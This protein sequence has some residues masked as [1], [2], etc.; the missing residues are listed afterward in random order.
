M[1]GATKGKK[2]DFFLSLKLSDCFWFLIFNLLMCSNAIEK[3][4]GF[5]YLD[6]MSTLILLAG[7]ILKCLQ[8]KERVRSEGMNYR[9]IAILSCFLLLL[10]GL[11]GNLAYG[12]QQ[13]FFPIAVD[14]FTCFKFPITLLSALY[15]FADN[16]RLSE[17]LESEAR[18]LILI[19]FMLGCINLVTDIGVGSTG[20]YGIPR[21]FELFFTHPTY[22]VFFAVG[23]SLLMLK[24]P[25]K[26]RAWIIMAA[27]VCCLSLRVKGIV[28][29]MIIILLLVSTHDVQRLSAYHVILAALTAVAVGWDSY[30]T[31]FQTNGF[32]RTE[33]VRVGIQ[34]GNSLFPLGSGFATFGSFMS[35][36][37]RYYS[38]LYYQYG[39]STIWG[40]G[41][42][43]SN[44]ASDTFW[45]TVIGQ[46]GWVGLMLYALGLIS[47]IRY[48]YTKAARYKFP[49]ICGFAYLLISSTSES[50]FFNPGSVFV[51]LC[52]AI[53]VAGGFTNESK[54]KF[55]H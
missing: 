1:N 45:P 14:A 10:V 29:A 54:T 8:T 4:N 16:E 23:L 2:R 42:H 43:D 36:T 33:L 32:A 9:S 48:A 15:L 26:N 21:A 17:L 34:L 31:Y 50:A 22:L 37:S 49:V 28:Y 44:F 46:F 18:F 53:G 27:I 20:R 3:L 30:S 41:P 51:A 40:L 19:T 52:M 13:Q 25:A 35:A 5:S 38:V 24:D 47:L 55:N 39:L 12:Y 7:A 11:A 6:E